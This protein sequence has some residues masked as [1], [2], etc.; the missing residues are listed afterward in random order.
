MLLCFFYLLHIWVLYRPK[1]SVFVYLLDDWSLCRFE[2]YLA[3]TAA[4]DKLYFWLLFYISAGWCTSTYQD[5]LFL[6]FVCRILVITEYSQ[7]VFGLSTLVVGSNPAH[8]NRMEIL[9]IN[10]NS[11]HVKQ[12]KISQVSLVM[13]HVNI[14]VISSEKLI[15][16]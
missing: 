1:F 9:V 7:L 5:W 11:N 10:S 8:A 6:D 13:K 4:I 2:Q 15:H 16:T 3:I 12:N 14:P